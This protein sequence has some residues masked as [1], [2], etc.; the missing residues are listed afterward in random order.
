MIRS[1]L[2]RSLLALVLTASACGDG[3]AEPDGSTTPDHM[4]VSLCRSEARAS[5]GDLAGAAAVFQDQ[6]H[7]RLHTFVEELQSRDRALAGKVLQAK[8][9][10]ETAFAGGSNQ[11]LIEFR[12]LALRLEVEK[13]LTATGAS[14]PPCR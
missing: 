13:A 5:N 2:P 14:V 8:E 4:V 10:V 12:I 3:S 7:A 9:S 6:V 11:E 1:S